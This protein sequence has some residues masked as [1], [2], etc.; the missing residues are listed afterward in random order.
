MLG[1]PGALGQHPAV[2]GARQRVAADQSFELVALRFGGLEHRDAR[3]AETPDREHD[4]QQAQAGGD[5]DKLERD[6]HGVRLTERG[7]MLGNQVFVRF[8]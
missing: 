4:D 2:A 6:Q 7:R 8:V 3:P 1:A 5:I